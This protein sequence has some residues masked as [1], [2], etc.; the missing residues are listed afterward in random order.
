MIYIYWGS[1]TKRTAD[2]LMGA[3]SKL[4]A[5]APDAHI[6]RIT[7]D[8]EQLDIEFLLASVGLFHS[9]RV[10]VLD[11]VFARTEYKKEI[12]AHL[13]ELAASQHIFF[14][15]EQD[16]TGAEVKKIEKHATKI[17]RHDVQSAI[18]NPFNTFALADALLAG[19]KKKLW[20]TLL[21]ALRAGHDAIDLHGI[22]FWGAKNLALAASS[23]SAEEAGMHPFVYTKT[24]AALGKF[25]TASIH[26]L[27]AELAELPHEARRQGVELEYALEY[28]VITR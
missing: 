13:P 28:F 12:M 2:A 24:R 7:D 1:D 27:V 4:R 3:I 17:V 6:E 25:S 18:R 20:L 8:A 11:G 14:L 21:E 16:L 26:A 23:D 22:L 15:R 10:V 9:A 19:D 5:R